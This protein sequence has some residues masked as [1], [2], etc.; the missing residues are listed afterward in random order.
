VLHI[1][2]VQRERDR[3]C[4][5]YALQAK[6]VDLLDGVDL[7]RDL[8]ALRDGFDRT[9]SSI[10]ARGELFDE[11]ASTP[12]APRSGAQSPHTLASAFGLPP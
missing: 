1:R 4:E 11:I 9:L 12:T 8:F 3:R 5:L 2:I 10:V 6:G 7:F